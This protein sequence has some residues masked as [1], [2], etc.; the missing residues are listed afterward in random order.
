MELLSASVRS[1]LSFRALVDSFAY[2][3]DNII[4]TIRLL[5]Y[6]IKEVPKEK[7]KLIPD[8]TE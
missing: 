4:L 8:M 5:H 7:G 6:Y 1:L 3:L 2:L